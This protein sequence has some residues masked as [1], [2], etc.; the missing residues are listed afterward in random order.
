MKIIRV[1]LCGL[2][3][4]GTLSS[5]P[6]YFG[7]DLSYVNEME[8]CGVIYK[9]KNVAKDPYR[10]FAD[11]GGNLVRLRLWKDPSWYKTLNSGKI[12]SDF[13]DV[14]RSIQRAHQNQMKVL[15]DFHLSDNWAD[16]SKQLVPLAWEPVV[17]NLAILKDSLYRYIHATL[18]ELFQRN[19]LP[20]MVQIGNETNKGIL[21]SA[22]DNKKYALDWPRNATLFN[23]AIRAVRD[24]ENLTQRK[25]KIGIHAAG[26]KDTGWLIDQFVQQGVT[27]FDMIGISYYWAWHKPTTIIETGAHIQSLKAK[28]NKDVLIFETGYIWTTDNQD[29]AGNII[30]EVHPDYA[31]AS[32]ANQKKWLIDLTKEVLKNKGSGVIYWESAWV[33]SPC[34]TQWG[35]GSHQEHATFF[36]FQ[37]NLI[38]TGGIQWMSHEYNSTVSIQSIA[39]KQEITIHVD[40]PSQQLR[41]WIQDPGVKIS[42]VHIYDL[43]GSRVFSAVPHWDGDYYSILF[44]S[45]PHGVYV[46]EAQDK[47]N[48]RYRQKFG[49]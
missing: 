28:Y 12:Y 33:S 18:F 34:F 24:I 19:L 46:A 23:S 14:A 20:E 35:K 17:N 15:L 36:D 47:K 37:Q 39:G 25:I 48:K 13:N 7:N 29:Q 21:L 9:E 38:D 11:H 42:A 6:F 45:L 8:D 27:D 44:T 49:F 5:Q 40:T 31:P 32:P 3:F 16:P 10:I 30:S 22:E 2:V 1:V 4:L 43:K 41:I 26:P